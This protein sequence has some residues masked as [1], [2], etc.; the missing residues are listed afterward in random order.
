MVQ[1][2]IESGSNQ[3]DFIKKNRF[4]WIQIRMD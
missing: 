2:Q 3:F 1:E 4:D